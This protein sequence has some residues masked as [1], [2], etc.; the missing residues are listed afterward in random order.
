VFTLL[1]FS[2]GLG[3]DHIENK[4]RDSYLA[5][6]LARRLLFSNELL[7]RD[8]ATDCLPRICLRG[9]LFINLCPAMVVHVT[10]LPYFSSFDGLG[11]LAC[12]HPELINSETISLTDTR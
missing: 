7:L 5:S 3:A 6:L 4:S 9:N 10:V 2:T 8:L 1:L 11:P 12:S